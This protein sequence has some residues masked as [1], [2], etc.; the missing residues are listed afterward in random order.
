MLSQR[1]FN[2]LAKKPRWGTSWLLPFL[3]LPPPQ[4]PRTH[5][6]C[7]GTRHTRIQ[8]FLALDSHPQSP[9]SGHVLSLLTFPR[10]P[11][12]GHSMPVPLCH[13]PWVW[14]LFHLPLSRGT[15]SWGQTFLPW[16]P[17]PSIRPDPAWGSISLSVFPW[18]LPDAEIPVLARPPQ[19]LTH[20]PWLA[21]QYRTDA[22]RLVLALHHDDTSI[23]GVGVRLQGPHPIGT[24]CFAG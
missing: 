15:L 24:H 7:Q 12:F 23:P 3:L 13:R 1:S 5:A 19:V 8:V 18:T 9:K 11:L 21:C 4:S 6:L 10:I 17:S 2:W 14:L 20:P 22:S 16:Y